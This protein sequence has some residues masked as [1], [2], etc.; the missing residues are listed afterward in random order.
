MHCEFKLE[1]LAHIGFLAQ[2]IESYHMR[3]E[4]SSVTVSFFMHSTEDRE[5]LLSSVSARLGLAKADLETGEMQGHFGNEIVSVKAN[6][7]GTR[8]Q[9]VASDML[10]YLSKRAKTQTL[11]DLGKS[12]DEH[13]ALYLR[14][15]R[16]E[17]DKEIAISDQEPI[18]I[19]LKPKIRGSRQSMREGYRELI[20]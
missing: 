13:D 17:I 8:G 19:K 3:P 14:I 5:R 2:G 6:I 18:R 20:S 10:M 7:T 9:D 16:Q 12:I 4:F 15:D 11:A 1:N